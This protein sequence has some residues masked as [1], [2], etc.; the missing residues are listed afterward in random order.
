[1]TGTT[2]SSGS[3]HGGTG[4]LEFIICKAGFLPSVYVAE[5]MFSATTLKF[6]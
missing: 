1:M 2:I 6:S 5:T 3:N 4:E